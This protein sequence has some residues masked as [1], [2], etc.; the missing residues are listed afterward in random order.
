MKPPVNPEIGRE[1]KVSELKPH[2]VVWILKEGRDVMATMWVV[3]IGD[4]YVHFFAQ[5][6]SIPNFLALRCGPD[7]EQITDD[8]HVKMQIF[9][10][11]GKP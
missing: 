4:V 5:H 10:Y 2:T 11:L 9:E 1:L 8:S 7:L 3:E 6:A